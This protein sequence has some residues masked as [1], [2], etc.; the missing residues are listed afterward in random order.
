MTIAKKT[1][2]ITG[3]NK[4]LHQL[5]PIITNKK[6]EE[7]IIIN[8]FGAVISH[9]YGCMIRSIVMGVYYEDVEEIYIIGEKDGKEHLITEEALFST[10]QESGVSKEMIKTIDYINVVGN[11]VLNWLVGPQDV[12]VI[13][14][15]NITL[16]N[17]HPLIPKS[18]SVFGY[19]VNSETNKFEA[20]L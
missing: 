19:I 4:K 16:I 14:Q 1:L 18:V 20:V 13:I 10:M 6:A 17:K 2:I 11:E 15:Q 12:K 3:L 5:F 7:L 8:S 9:P